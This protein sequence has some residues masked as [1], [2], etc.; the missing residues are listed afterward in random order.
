MA[1]KTKAVAVV[2]LEGYV[3]QCCDSD[4]SVLQ[5][6]LIDK[7][8]GS[9]LEQR[10]TNAPLHAINWEIQTDTIDND[11]CHCSDPECNSFTK[12]GEQMESCEPTQCRH[13]QYHGVA[14]QHRAL[15]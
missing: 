3:R 12:T 6:G 10:A 8:A 11:G 5:I 7:A 14:R 9:I 13:R 1:D 4:V 15:S 2:Q